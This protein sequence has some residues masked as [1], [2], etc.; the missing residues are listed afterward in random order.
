MS[1]DENLK[2]TPH[3]IAFLDL[4]GATNRIEK[5][6][7]ASLSEMNNLYIA[8]EEASVRVNANFHSKIQF[9]TFSDNVIIVQKLDQ[10]P[11]NEQLDKFVVLMAIFQFLALLSYS[12]LVRGAVCV[13]DVFID[14]NFVWGKG[15]VAAHNLES[16]CAVYPRVILDK[17]CF[18]DNSLYD[19]K[20]NLV[21]SH[22]IT[23][24]FDDFFIVD[25]FESARLTYPEEE[26][27]EYFE[28]IYFKIDKGAKETSFDKYTQKWNYIKM[29]WRKYNDYL[30]KDVY[31]LSNAI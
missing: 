3:L 16:Q 28:D 26:F 22:Q 20:K 4:L 27:L 12:W 30:K 5:D 13:G 25:F 24:D 18:S 21:Y 14:E 7:N 15:L 11:L 19:E 1:N 6:Q 9:K 2:C 23:R 10:R 29:Y 8:L 17:S 31:G